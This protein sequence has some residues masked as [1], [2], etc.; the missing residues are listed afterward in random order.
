VECTSFS[1]VG[2]AAESVA[3]GADMAFKIPDDE[4]YPPYGTPEA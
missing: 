4:K 2:L 1:L 3:S